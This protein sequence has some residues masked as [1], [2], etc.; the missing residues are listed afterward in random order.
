MTNKI[1]FVFLIIACMAKDSLI[2]AMIMDL[3]IEVET[4]MQKF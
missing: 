3:D 4:K 2:R 1:N